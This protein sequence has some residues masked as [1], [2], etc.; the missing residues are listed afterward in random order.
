MYFEHYKRLI[1]L[2]QD[3]SQNLS[4]QAREAANFLGLDYEERQVGYGFMAG[5]VDS[6]TKGKGLTHV[7]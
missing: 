7:L 5:A 3:P 2:V 1:Y 4:E 6:I